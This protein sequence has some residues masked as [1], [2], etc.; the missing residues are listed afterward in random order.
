MNLEQNLRRAFAARE[1]LPEFEEVVMAR[2][3]VAAQR[4]GRKPSRTILYGTIV[5]VTAAAAMVAAGLIDMTAIPSDVANSTQQHA[6]DAGTSPSPLIAPASEL[7]QA[8]SA[9]KE[10]I[11]AVN[12]YTV[13]VQ[14]LNEATGAA[15]PAV[16]SF[17]TALLDNLRHVSGLKLIEDPSDGAAP[18]GAADYELLVEGY[19]PNSGKFTGWVTLI[20]PAGSVF[21]RKSNWIRCDAGS[22]PV[23]ALAQ[24]RSMPGLSISVTTRS[25]SP[26]RGWPGVVVRG[27]PPC[28]GPASGAALM[29]EYLRNDVLPPDPE[30]RP[31]FTAQLLDLAQDS[32]QRLK[33]LDALSRKAVSGSG[34]STSL[35]SAALRGAINLVANTT[36]PKVRVSVWRALRGIRNPD[37]LP[38]LVASLR[39]DSSIEVRVEA[40]ATL[41][42]GFRADPGGRAV[43]EATA[44]RDSHPMLRALAQRAL[45]G[46]A[47][48]E[49]YIVSSL[50]N[51][52]LPVVER[53]EAFAYQMYGTSPGYDDYDEDDSFEPVSAE[54]RRFLDE[55]MIRVLS[56][57]LPKTGNRTDDD[58]RERAEPLMGAILTDLL[59]T[60]DP[61]GVRLVLEITN[62][63]SDRAERIGAL[64]ETS[65]GVGYRP[66]GHR[67]PVRFPRLRGMLEKISV[68]DP[69]PQLRQ[70]AAEVLKE[71]AAL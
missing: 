7:S 30:Q 44:R 58:F 11:P 31:R 65:L 17:Y 26:P 22:E 32:K 48:W 35:D 46:D 71:A 12:A 24:V 20:P 57:V 27:Q 37:L 63:H 2:V 62:R 33:A 38:S 10:V 16:E 8:G 19:G 25:N 41:S 34:S 60:D 70:I 66:T 3:S 21:G 61:A 1:P 40:L 52:S 45:T 69:D 68:D 49:Q 64:A 9:P 56:Q 67:D 5:V 39:D 13:R 14:F 4:P 42:A 55:E 15:I 43:L 6:V 23:G 54:N 18:A 51:T 53:M 36:D 28:A 50:Q 29:M 59:R 47:A